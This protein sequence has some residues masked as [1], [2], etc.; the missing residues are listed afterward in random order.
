MELTEPDSD[1]PRDKRKGKR[2]HRQLCYKPNI[3]VPKKDAAAAATDD[4]DDDTD[5]EDDT[6]DE[7]LSGDEED[8]YSPDGR[9]LIVCME[10]HWQRLAP[11][12]SASCSPI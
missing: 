4:L 12:P 2:K 10:D 11:P 7:I 5:P 8:D 1:A 9:A 3:V 6:D